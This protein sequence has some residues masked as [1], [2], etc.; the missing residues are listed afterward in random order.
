[1]SFS[2]EHME[3]RLSR[4]ASIIARV[5]ARAAATASTALRMSGRNAA[6]SLPMR[7]TAA[8]SAHHARGGVVGEVS[9]PAPALPRS[10]VAG[11]ADAATTGEQGRLAPSGAHALAVGDRLIC[12]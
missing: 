6:N 7:V 1:M 9:I 8:A 4:C 11:A 10:G 3:R 5:S 12:F 2:S